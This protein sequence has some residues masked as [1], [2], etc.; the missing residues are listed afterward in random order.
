MGKAAPPHT[1]NSQQNLERSVS[2]CV[3]A[4]FFFHAEHLLRVTFW[5][6]EKTINTYMTCIYKHELQ[7]QYFFLCAAG[8]ARKHCISVSPVLNAAAERCL[9][10]NNLGQT[11]GRSTLFQPW[12]R[13]VLGLNSNK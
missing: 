13:I 5:R 6:P 11:L 4:V 9:C 7:G 10:A 8:S 2:L 3:L 12:V 1:H